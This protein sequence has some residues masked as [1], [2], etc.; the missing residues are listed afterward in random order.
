MEKEIL[1]HIIKEQ[2]N[3]DGLPNSELINFMDL[4]SKEFEESK[5]KIIQETFHLDKVEELY[6]NVLKVYE[7]RGK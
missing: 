6:N 5:N 2:K 7:R 3:L 4:L 1:E